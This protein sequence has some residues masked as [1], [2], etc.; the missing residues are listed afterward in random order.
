MQTEAY[1]VAGPTYA[2]SVAATQHADVNVVPK[3]AE[4]CNYALF[5][6]TGTTAVCVVTSNFGIAT[7]AVVFPVDGTPTIPTS[8]VLPPSMPLPVAFSVLC[9]GTS[10]FNVSAIGSAAGPTIV[11]VTPLASM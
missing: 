9:Y 11:Y 3:L 4:T 1:R 5:W 8:F 2:L 10:G 6:N 7:P